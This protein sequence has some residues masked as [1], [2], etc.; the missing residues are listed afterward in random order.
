MGHQSP[1]PITD[2][3]GFL[4]PFESLPESKIPESPDD[5]WSL[6]DRWR[7]LDLPRRRW[8]RACLDPRFGW[9]GP[10]SCIG[11]LLLGFVVS[12]LLYL[13][14]IGFKYRAF[15]RYII[16][17]VVPA[18][19]YFAWITIAGVI[20][21]HKMGYY[22]GYINFLAL[23]TIPIVMFSPSFLL[24]EETATTYRWVRQRPVAG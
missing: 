6:T 11:H 19:T 16:C 13:I 17:A 8:S 23:S 20:L 10:S 24:S 4:I 18:A 2:V 9:F 5:D 12:T 1:R 21:L 15:T 7:E 3:H 14:T 22:D